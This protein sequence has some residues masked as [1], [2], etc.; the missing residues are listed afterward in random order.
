MT[1][2]TPQPLRVFVSY[3]PEDDRYRRALEKHLGA[4]Q[5][6]GAVE[7]WSAQR[8][9]GG[10]EVRPATRRALDQADVV[11]ALVSADFV[12]SSA[13]EEEL[14]PA[15]AKHRAGEARV[16]PVRVRPVD[17]AGTA[18]AKLA[19]LPPGDKAVSQREDADEA[20]VE[21]VAALRRL[22]ARGG[23]A[24]AE[25]EGDVDLTEDDAYV[26][27]R[28]GRE[29]RF[30]RSGEIESFGARKRDTFLSEI[31]RVCELREARRER[32]TQVYKKPSLA[33]FNE[34]AE[35]LSHEAKGPAHWFVLAALQRPLTPEDV[36]CF[37]RDILDPFRRLHSDAFGHLVGLSLDGPPG[38]EA[39]AGRQGVY[40]YSLVEY[41]GLIDFEPYTRRLLQK[42]DSDPSYPPHLYVP[43]RAAIAPGMPRP[44]D[45]AAEDALSEID[46]LL[47]QEAG[48]LVLILGDFGAGKTFLLRQLARRLIERRAPPYPVLLEMR[49][50]DKSQPLAAHLAASGLE[51]FDMQAFR[52]MLENG[53]IAL[54]FDGF[55]E[56][57]SRVRYERATEHFNG[58]LEATQGRAK[59]V[60]T[61]R[62]QHFYSDDQIGNELARRAET[63]AG[64][65][66][67]AIRPFTDG[68]VR[69]F[70]AGALKTKEAAEERVELLRKVNDLLELAHNPRMLSFIATLPAER[71][72]KAH[73]RSGEITSATLYKELLDWWFE[74]EDKRNRFRGGPRALTTKDRWRAV[75]ALAQRL[76]ATQTA[77]VH[78]SALPEDVARAIDDLDARSIDL[79][80]AAHDVGSG[81]LLVRDAAGNFSF[82]H[83]SV[84]EWLVAN[85]AAEHVH[86]GD[87]APA[88][89]EV[90]MSE[91][92]ADFFWGRLGRREA[93]AWARARLG[94]AADGP[95]KANALR[96][97]ARLRIRNL[98]GA[99]LRGQDLRGDDLSEQDLSGA[100]LSG[101]QLTGARLRGAT[102]T[103]ASL[104]GAALVRADLQGASLDGA[105]LQGADLSFA[106]LLGA[107][108]RGAKLRGARLSYA[109]LVGAE[110]DE[111]WES[112]VPEESRFGLATLG[113]APVTRVVA[114]PPSNCRSAAFHPD[115][116]FLASTHNDCTIRI[117]DA[118]SGRLL[119]VLRGHSG[120]VWSV[121]FSPDGRTLASGSEDKTVRLWDV[122]AAAE[123]R[124]LSGHARRV[125]SV[126]FSPDGRTLASGSHDLTVRLW[127]VATAEERH[128]LKGHQR[129][130]V[131][132]AFS[133][134]GRTLASGSA[135]HAVRLWDVPAAEERC[136]LVGHWDAIS[137][138]AFSPDGRT[139]ASASNDQT[140]RL[141]NVAAARPR[142]VL[143]GDFGAAL[144]VAFSPDGRSLALGSYDQTV[145]LWD[146]ATLEERRPL[147][148]HSGA[149]SSVAFSPDGRSLASSSHDR[150]VR[151]W[152]VEAAEERQVFKVRSSAVSSV[153]FSPDGRSL[154]SGSHDHAVRL[155]DVATAEG[156]RV[157][158]G[159]SSAVL[160]LAFSPDGRTL[161]SGSHDRT[162]RLWDVAT[163][164]ERRVIK[165]HSSAVSSVAF[166][167]DGRALASGSDD[168]TVCLWNMTTLEAL[169]LV[170][171]GHSGYVSCVAFS[172]DGRA[173]SS[174][175]NDHSVRLWDAKLAEERLT[176]R[177]HSDAVLSV[178]F[179]TD[180][181]AIAS[182]SYDRT[183]RLWNLTT[184][185]ERHI[186]RGHS[187]PVRSVAFSP[188]GRTLASGSDDETVRLWDVT[189]AK[190]RGLLE[191]HQSGIL[192]VAFSPDGRTL[193]A[194][195]RDAITLWDVPSAT[196]IANLISRPDGWA[197]LLPDGRYKMSGSLS[198]AFWYA[199]GLCRFEPGE[200]D[201]WVPSIRAMPLGEE[202]PRPP[203]PAAQSLPSPVSSRR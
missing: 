117:W 84:L 35:I 93:E 162:V 96:V 153:A 159:H 100:D 38:F 79:Q 48:R 192:S 9:E 142:G 12:S 109:A 63:I 155:W 116:A 6:S 177:G 17:L 176:M 90:A 10:E 128:V 145:R 26:L 31:L 22:L 123:R 34:H 190:E 173:L 81:T 7:V 44:D 65:R 8:I 55:D 105:D 122:E 140:L 89:A 154:A 133:P 158:K 21:V 199:I 174:G 87:A 148:G 86:R 1:S 49:S 160:C 13:W 54:L 111:G 143:T 77:S 172:P 78:H 3:A 73:S 47:A 24:G 45:A 42:L 71:L 30:E 25:D 182:G 169:C 171:I 200:L 11:L 29:E 120:A 139:L 101:A 56:L 85:D 124:T 61:S 163:A 197:V 4:L 194:S 201:P 178:A 131:S 91:L 125:W 170:F 106:R 19:A 28:A 186:L 104:A 46:G 188:D 18:L 82:V 149:I 138:V 135:D 2:Q 68:Q 161:A 88:V 14:G 60:V 152:D 15:L 146:A 141:W 33:P 39:D 36:A 52:Y 150:T 183:V 115:G 165:G 69:Q 198:G 166:S 175:S 129:F 98:R 41:Q 70:F 134:D 75:T 179:S 107:D 16:V 95:A 196:R 58:V 83:R 191:G 189:T 180:G 121:V 151:L 110:L 57:V 187:R 53:Q 157:I 94:E 119:R 108:L 92:M 66:V 59:V 156:R 27:E 72:Y 130:V 64:Y 74:Q 103:G 118:H 114:A 97:L 43:Q 23:D 37:K 126:A 113:A 62:T 202:L 137:S 40:V 132:V 20:W 195:G 193:A 184:A 76:W 127:D 102:L 203:S 5:K 185:K 144:S 136:I 80:D 168:H 181:R 99:D 167:P 67:A 112:E 50:L 164:E 51:R 147:K 32:K